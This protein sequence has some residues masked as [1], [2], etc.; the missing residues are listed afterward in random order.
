MIPLTTA[1]V[2]NFGAY[3]AKVHNAMMS[4][5]HHDQL[6]IVTIHSLQNKDKPDPSPIV[7][8]PPVSGAAGASDPQI[9]DRVRG[10]RAWI[11]PIVSDDRTHQ[12]SGKFDDAKLD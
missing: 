8:N 10:I 2:M 6:G 5:A 11:L 9:A 7:D 3:S 4:M 12:D 1:D